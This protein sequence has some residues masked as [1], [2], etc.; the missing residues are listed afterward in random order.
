MQVFKAMPHMVSVTVGP[1]DTVPTDE[2]AETQIRELRIKPSDN[3]G[4]IVHCDYE[5]AQGTSS[6]SGYIGPSCEGKTFT[7]D[8][9]A[10]LFAYLED[11][12]GTPDEPADAKEVDQA[13]AAM[14]ED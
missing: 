5:P 13:K 14:A 3:G 12:L 10:S 4:F 9:V 7:F 8:N 1:D 11:A 6:M 2:S